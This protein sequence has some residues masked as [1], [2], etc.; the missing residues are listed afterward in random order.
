MKKLSVALV[1]FLLTGIL[2]ASEADFS[3]PVIHV[4]VVV[5]DLEKSLAFYKDVVGM[6]SGGS[7]DVNEDM[8]KRTG[9]AA[10]VPFHVEILKLDKDKDMTQFKLM[11]FGERTRKQQNQFIYDHTG[12]RYVTIF[13]NE[14]EPIIKRIKAHHVRMLGDTPTE[15]GPNNYFVLIQDPD[16]I[17]VEL[18][19]P[20]K[21]Q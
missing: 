14:L 18:I 5:S 12:M 15:L 1:S 11:S 17:F 3:N 9:L 20:M 21:K 16:G 6:V 4:G 13:V 7:F 10:G 2:C 19:G 8:S